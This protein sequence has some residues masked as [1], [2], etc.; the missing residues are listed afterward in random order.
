MCAT[1]AR[2]WCLLLAALLGAGLSAAAAEETAPPADMAV[3]AGT[4]AM[5]DGQPAADA[6]IAL[7]VYAA[8]PFTARTDAAGRFALTAPRAKLRGGLVLARK[9]GA[10]LGQAALP[11]E[12]PDAG[13]LN[14]LEI[15]L[16]PARWLEI[17]VAKNGAPVDTASVVVQSQYHSIASAKSNADG[18]VRLAVPRDAALQFIL[19]SKPGEG[20]DYQLFRD[21][22]SPARDPY[23]L[24]QDHAAPIPLELAPTRMVTVHVQD[25]HEQPLSGVEVTPWLLRLPNKGDSANLGSIWTRKT[26]AAG[27]ATFDLIPQDLE[28]GLEFWTSK[29]GLIAT[30]RN[31]LKPS[32]ASARLVATLLPLT[33]VSGRVLNSDGSPAAAISVSAAGGSRE[34]SSFHDETKTDAE[35]RFKFAVN[36]D[37]YCMFAALDKDQASVAECRIVRLGQPIDDLELRLAPAA[38]V[39]GQVTSRGEPVA[40][41][42]VSL[43]LEPSP[44]Y[45]ELPQEQQLP[46]PKDS[47]HGIAP[48]LVRHVQT[49][50]EGR[51]AFSA[52]PG[53]YYLTANHLTKAPQFTIAD[54]SAVEHDLALST[55]PEGKLTG[56]VVLGDQPERGVAE[57]RVIGYSADLR[58]VVRATTDAEGRFEER[59]SGSPML[60][61]AFNADKSL[62]ALQRISAEQTEVTLRLLPLAT[63]GGVLVD[64]QTGQPAAKR[65]LIAYIRVGPE[66][67]PFMNAAEVSST[68]DDSGR[69][70]LQ[71]LIVAA[72]YQISGVADV[73]GDGNARSWQ[74]VTVLTASAPGPLPMGDL[75]LP[76]GHHRPTVEDDIERAYAHPD[77]GQRLVQLLSDAEHAYSQV[78]VVAASPTG[79]AGRRYFEICHRSATGRSQER[80]KNLHEFMVLAV[81]PAKAGDAFEKHKLL[82]PG[83][84]DEATFAILNPDGS[85]VAQTN[86]ADLS[87]GDTID[88]K[89]L[90]EFLANRRAPLTNARRLM[91]EALDQAKREDKRVLVQ[92]GGPGCSWCIV[93]SRY[94]DAHKTLIEKDY[95]HLKLDSRMPEAEAVIGELR[96]Q[97]EGGIPW[98]VILDA[99]GQKLITSDA[100]TGNIGYPGE[101]GSRTHW[102]K[103]LTTTRQR[104][105]DDELAE[106]MA[107]LGKQP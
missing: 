12:L 4:V 11:D 10:L 57:I 21:V 60:F 28:H 34:L 14:R 35:G 5:A 23:Q 1:S 66:D 24:P 16:E 102:Q 98:M 36:P 19:A 55:P 61:E 3:L 88:A 46:N 31:V 33:P 32:D 48:R 63:A 100:E 59:P 43:Y 70:S 87:T 75:L 99:H 22:D 47:R 2:W 94:L 58:Q 93:L 73:D 42:Y 25:Q 96:A 71:G 45:Y 105:T 86:S 52:P 83:G 15:K 41:E 77:A 54:G 65:Q 68:T 97:K 20:V 56:R 106:L 104:L 53:K 78:L 82:A 101:P 37:C 18:K 103:M 29:S 76:K 51:Y 81:D 90:A 49:D 74:L 8:P 89:L 107:P 85:I 40:N 30:E 72:D 67:G 80:P 39:F 7:H 64:A 91:R 84:P 17:A 62:G 92:E 26:D 13:E 6:E 38:R 9:D 95:V 69:F 27:D 50:A 44:D 79:A